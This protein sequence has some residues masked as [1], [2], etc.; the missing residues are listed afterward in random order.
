MALLSTDR[1][2][3]RLDADGDIYIGEAGSVGIT[4]IDGVAQLVAIALRLFK[5]EWFLNLNKGMPWFQEIFGEK[6][7]EPLVRKRIAEIVLAVPGVTGITSLNLSFVSSAR[8]LTITLTVR[9]AF[10]DTP[11]DFIQFVIGGGGT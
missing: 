8:Q 4:G 10:G 9:T 5:E 3:R 11:P 2:D 7:D 1:L 6:L